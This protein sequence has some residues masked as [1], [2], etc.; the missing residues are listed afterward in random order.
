MSLSDTIFRGSSQVHI[1]YKPI[2]L[3]ICEPIS[4]HAVGKFSTVRKA[5]SVDKFLEDPP[6]TQLFL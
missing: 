6:F 3:A 5:Y 2:K 1:F 4:Q